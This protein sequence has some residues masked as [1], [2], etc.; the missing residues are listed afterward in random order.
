[1]NYKHDLDERLTLPVL[2]SRG[3]YPLPR[4]VHLRANAGE[5]RRNPLFRLLAHIQ[6]HAHA[7]QHHKQA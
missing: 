2:P 5:Y 7:G 3:T 1:M 6:Q 4:I